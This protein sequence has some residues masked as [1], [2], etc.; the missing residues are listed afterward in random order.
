MLNRISLFR[1]EEF[2]SFCNVLLSVVDRAFQAVDGRGGDGGND[3]FVV[4]GDAVYQ[5]WGPERRDGGR[6]T[7]KIND[8]ISKARNL[9]ATVFPGLKRFNFVTP[10]DLTVEQH[11]SLRSAARASGLEAESWGESRLLALLCD[12][13]EVKTEFP[14][15]L[16]PDILE[17]LRKMSSRIDGDD[18]PQDILDDWV[19]NASDTHYLLVLQPPEPPATG[20]VHSY[21]YFKA[22]LHSDA[23]ARTSI[24][25]EEEEV[26]LAAIQER[27]WEDTRAEMSSPTANRV[28]VEHREPNL[29]FHRAWG[30]WTDGTMG[31][32]GTLP[33][34]NR[35]GFYSVA[36]LVFDLTR[37]F[38]LASFMGAQGPGLI[39]VGYDPGFLSVH[40]EP[41]DRRAQLRPQLRLG[42]VQHVGRPALRERSRENARAQLRD[43]SDLAIQA[44]NVAA[45]LVVPLVK[46][47]HLARI[48]TRT[49]A[50]SIPRLLAGTRDLLVL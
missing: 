5:M 38:R 30:W 44:H 24:E 21:R 7:R 22:H 46:D 3:G 1:G 34:L 37:F 20:E 36:E 19:T 16:I 33:D 32:A 18:D 31:M 14:H 17:E 10:F 42:G 43:L 8:S 28:L 35:E 50:E 45:E 6:L 40:F 39:R 9:R 49:F 47:F 11:V 48:S 12:H 13:P 27:F 25:P 23:L 4:A 41:S 2:Q 15:L 26:F 29:R